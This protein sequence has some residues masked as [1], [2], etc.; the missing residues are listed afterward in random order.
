MLVQQL[1]KEVSCLLELIEGPVAL[2]F[3]CQQV[4]C[5]SAEVDHGVGDSRGGGDAPHDSFLIGKSKRL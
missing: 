3:K 2:D 4:Q 5:A 1:C